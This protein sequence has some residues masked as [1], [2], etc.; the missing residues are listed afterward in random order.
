LGV[1]ISAFRVVGDVSQRALAALADSNRDFVSSDFVR[2]EV[3][4]K[5]ICYGRTFERGFYEAF[6]L[7]AK[8]VVPATRS[9]VA[10]ADVEAER[11]GLSAIDALHVAAAKRG[12]C[13]ELLT[14][15]LPTKPLFRVTGLRIISLR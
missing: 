15:E 3:L 2:L 1:L 6:F 14:T 10:E 12:R 13:A 7:R 9:L 11:W 8:R 5:P 4:P